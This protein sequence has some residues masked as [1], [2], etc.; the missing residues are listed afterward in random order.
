M[1]PGEVGQLVV[2]GSHVMQGYWNLP[3]VTANVFRPGRY[4]AERLL[5]T[6]DYFTLD[7]D[8]FLYFKGRRDDMIKSRGE[9][10]YPKEVEDVLYGLDGVVETLVVGDPDPILGQAIKAYVVRQDS[11]EL[12]QRQVRQHCANNLEDFKVPRR[13]EFCD[14]LPKTSS[15]KIRRMRP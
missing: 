15:L 5:Y 8:G 6:G 10:V 9:M 12:T 4:P 2:R 1:V 11:S 7:E 13:V 3:D 14:S